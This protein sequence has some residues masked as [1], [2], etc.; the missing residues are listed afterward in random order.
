MNYS[1][2]QIK[3]AQYRIF[4]LDVHQKTIVIAES[5]EKGEP[6]YVKTIENN[7]AAVR[8]FFQPVKDSVELVFT[9]YEAGG[10]GNGLHRLLVKMGITN[11]IAA[12]S[13]LPKSPG[14]K[15]KNDKVD[16][17][18]LARL[19]RYMVL[20]GELKALHE[21][22]V[23]EVDDEAIREK[24]RQRDT[25][26]KQAK[27]TMNQITSMLRRHGKKYDLT[28]TKWT[29]TY[30]DWLTRVDFSH[31]TIN[32]T[33]REYLDHLSTLEAL[34][35]KCD[36]EINKLVEEW[37][38]APLVK[39][40]SCFRGFQQL[41]STCL[42]AEIGVFNR[43]ETA[44]QIMSFLG[45][46]C[47]ESSS[48]E[49]VTLGR[50]TKTGNTRARTLLVEAACAASRKPKPK[51]AFVRTCPPDLPQEVIDHAYKAQCRLYTKYWR[52]VNKGKSPNKAKIA[53]ARELIGFIWWVA[54]MIESKMSIQEEPK[55]TT[56][57]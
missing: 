43:F 2:A 15:V 38:K 34:V 29:K 39:A 30:R 9:T 33:F 13:K 42:V 46:T 23:P 25:F 51:S 45:M 54:V 7:E 5:T 20:N 24:T 12:P 49:S 10:C 26:K 19:L 35:A 11:T 14:K 18:N 8:A 32:T 52:L 6:R 50:I 28:K 57:A 47:S 53:V 4:G 55:M 56:A 1:S 21:V 44:P 36:R 31:A 40:F 17:I 16:A 3:S 48:G 27:S 41:A 37:N 22:Y